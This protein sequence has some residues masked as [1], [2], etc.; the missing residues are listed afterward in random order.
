MLRLECNQFEGRSWWHFGIIRCLTWLTCKEG[1]SQ[2]NADSKN[3]EDGVSWVFTNVYGPV[4]K[5]E[6]ENF[7]DELRAISGLWSDPWCVDGDFN[8]IRFSWGA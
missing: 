5:R 1:C 6:R 2:F 4:C 8:I 7:Y 3:Y